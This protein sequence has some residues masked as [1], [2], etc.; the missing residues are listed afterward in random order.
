M[1]ERLLVEYVNR[2]F[3]TTGSV[4]GKASYEPPT[5]PKPGQAG[6]GPTRPQIPLPEFLDRPLTR[7]VVELIEE[8]VKKFPIRR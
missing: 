3:T 5:G 6:D 7:K 4:E 1:S 8:A 2:L